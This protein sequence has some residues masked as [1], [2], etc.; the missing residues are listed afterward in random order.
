ML[1]ELLFVLIG[2]SGD[3]FVPSPLSNSTTFAIPSDFP[4]LHPAERE[5][6]NR[7]GQLGWTYSQI[8]QFIV[9]VKENKS[10]DKEKPHGAYILTLVT[11]IE[12]TLNDYRQDILDMEKRIL[13][14][15]DDLGSNVVPLSLLTAD[16]SRWE[17]LLPA[18]WKFI[19]LLQDNPERYHGCKL[20]DLLMDQAKTGV[21]EFRHQIE[22]MMIQLYNVLYRQLTAWMVDGQWTDPDNEFFIIPYTSIVDS[23]PLAARTGWNRLYIIAYDRIPS[24]LSH[25]LVE[26]I[27]FVGKAIAT[28]NEMDK[29][30][31]PDAMRKKHL[32][33]LISL[34]SSNSNHQT[35][36][37]WIR[38]P[39]ELKKI[40][41]EVR[42]STADWLF[43]QVLVGDH[44]LHRY[45]NSFRRL[46]LLN[47][48]DF[49]ANFIQECALWRKRS[50]S[51]SSSST[52]NRNNDNT[53]SVPESTFSVNNKTPSKTAMIFRYQE[54]NALLGKASIGT[55]AEDQLHGFS[56]LLIDDETSQYPFSDLLLVELRVILT[57]DLQW[58]IDLFLGESDLKNYSNLWSFLISLKNTQ[59]LLN[60]LWKTLRT[61]SNNNTHREETVIRRHQNTSQFEDN[62]GYQERLVWRL[63]SLMLFWIDTLWNHIQTNVIDSHYQQLID[64]TTPPT[65]TTTT[66]RKSFQPKAKLDFEEIQVAHEKFLQNTM[67]GCL[68]TSDDCVETVHN[69]L[70]ICSDFC[71]L[72]ERISEDG[73]WR[74]SKRRRTTEKTA[75]E[76]INQW[77]KSNTDFSWTKS[78]REIQEKFTLSTESFFILA[79]SQQPEIKANG[80]LDV[81]LMQ[82]DYNKWFSGQKSKP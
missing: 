20:F 15:E 8:N 52:R 33:L 6:L 46:F 22:K 34:H 76:I 40:V 16:L 19:R 70:K 63:R 80:R 4:L 1:H 56:L 14:K 44:G 39:Q 61:G 48:G 30:L 29:I 67:H 79:S 82:L 68:L 7:L 23:N 26:S 5:G 50:L 57:Y 18:L 74:R 21:I 59:M 73:E 69:I 62:D 31:I 45:L 47:Y 60:N 51:S 58:P 54:L 36:S 28:V 53:R 81:L 64:I 2:H 9:T 27:L 11:A 10:R 35:S 43:S 49:A 32:Q 71:E 3:V 24:H 77:T 41:N 25:S 37:P 38:Y 17:T 78:V 55:D 42:R 12:T 13:N 65:S 72:M 66:K 75:A